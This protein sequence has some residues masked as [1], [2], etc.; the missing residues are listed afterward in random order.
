MQTVNCWEVVL[1]MEKPHEYQNRANIN[2][3]VKI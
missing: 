2:Q 3:H 1:A